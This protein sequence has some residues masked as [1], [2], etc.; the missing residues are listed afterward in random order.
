[1][2]VLRLNQQVETLSF[3]TNFKTNS[4]YLRKSAT[5]HRPYPAII[6]EDPKLT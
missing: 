4:L 5:G 2:P 6:Q 3:D 1:M